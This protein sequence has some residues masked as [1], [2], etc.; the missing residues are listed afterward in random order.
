MKKKIFTLVILLTLLISLFSITAS[1][2]GYTEWELSAD[3]KTLTKN[4][5]EEY[6]RVE[7]ND[8][9][10]LSYSLFVYNDDVYVEEE[11]IYATVYSGSKDADIVYLYY[12]DNVIAYTNSKGASELEKYLL[13]NIAKGEIYSS[14]EYTTVTI[15][16]EFAESILAY[17]ASGS[18][19]DVSYRDI[20]Y[21]ESYD[22]ELY[23][24]DGCVYYVAGSVFLVDG[25]YYYVSYDAPLSAYLLSGD[26]LTQFKSY[27]GNMTP[28]TTNYTYEEG[29][30]DD[31]FEIGLDAASAMAVLIV[32]ISVFGIVLP[33]IPTLFAL[34]KLFRARVE[35]PIPY[36]I[37]FSVSV[38]WCALGVAGLIVLMI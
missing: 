8:I 19:A 21:A 10:A 34:Y 12:G 7:L 27:I 36:Y 30:I 14:F 13:G 17:A 31:I 16:A 23:S 15:S 4:W 24:D 38:I 5:E 3:G 18:C 32:L 37:L 20:M 26:T 1:A 22:I 29:D 28:Y 33:I 9:F 6:T 35:Y 25:S 11:G 2:E